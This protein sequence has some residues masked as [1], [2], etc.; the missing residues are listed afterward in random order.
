MIFDEGEI[1]RSKTNSIRVHLVIS[2][3]KAGQS[4][5][6]SMQNGPQFREENNLTSF[7]EKFALQCR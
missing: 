6:K 3:V 1:Q 5:E 2:T 4:P 7:V